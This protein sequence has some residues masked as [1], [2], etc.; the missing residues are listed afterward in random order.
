MV[1]WQVTG[2]PVVAP[3]FLT[4]TRNVVGV[5]HIDRPMLKLSA[6]LALSSLALPPQHDEWH[7]PK[8]ESAVISG[9]NRLSRK[10][11]M[12]ET[13][14]GTRS[15]GLLLFQANRA[16]R[17][18]LRHCSAPSIFGLRD[19]PFPQHDRSATGCKPVPVPRRTG[20]NLTPVM[21]RGEDHS[22][23]HNHH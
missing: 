19:V 13:K 20:A 17:G 2:N 12:S 1:V 11:E 18:E 8:S 21:H 16:P 7:V 15:P 10:P 23:D 4:G 5:G 3:F 6:T 9:E 14:L 22:N